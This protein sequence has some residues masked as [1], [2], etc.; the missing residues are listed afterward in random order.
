L[1][2]KHTVGEVERSH[3]AKNQ[4]DASS[5][6]D[7]TPTYDRHWANASTRA[8]STAGVK[9]IADATIAN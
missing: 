4:L 1:R 6:F 2:Q 7:R 8:S 9:I 5:H 3:G